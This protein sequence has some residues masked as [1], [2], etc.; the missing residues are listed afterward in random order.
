[1]FRLLRGYLIE[2]NIAGVVIYSV[3]STD[4]EIGMS[5]LASFE[6]GSSFF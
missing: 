6:G 3:R 1:M 5:D 2:Y 4:H